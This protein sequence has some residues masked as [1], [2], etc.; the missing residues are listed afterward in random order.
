MKLWL[1]KS[2]LQLCARLS[3]CLCVRIR[4]LKA[5][6][7]FTT[8]TQQIDE[9]IHSVRTHCQTKCYGTRTIAQSALTNTF[10]CHSHHR[11]HRVRPETDKTTV[12]SRIGQ[13]AHIQTPINIY[14][15]YDNKLPNQ[16]ERSTTHTQSAK[17]TFARNSDLFLCLWADGSLFCFCLFIGGCVRDFVIARANL[18]QTLL[19]NNLTYYSYISNIYSLR[20]VCVCVCVPKGEASN[21]QK[22]YE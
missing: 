17:T 21:F 13:T 19:L 6:K 16:F 10:K 9:R 3:V 1:K 22:S 11:R 2:E 4:A 7:L 8:H 12:R 15:D 14:K 18:T 20:R 5:S